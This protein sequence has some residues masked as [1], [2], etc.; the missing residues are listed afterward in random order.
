MSR[1][2]RFSSRALQCLLLASALGVA[3]CGGAQDKEPTTSVAVAKPATRPAAPKQNLLPAGL[4]TTALNDFETSRSGNPLDAIFS[5]NRPEGAAPPVRVALLLPLSGQAASAGRVMLKAAQLALFDAGE[6]R[7][8]LLPHDT[9][10]TVEGA[11]AAARAAL[12]DGAN[13]VLGPLFGAHVQAVAEVVSARKVPVLAFSNDQ[14]A[15]GNGAAVLGLTPETEIR[16][17]LLRARDEGL[18]EIAAFLPDSPYGLLVADRM[19]AISAET[20]TTI[21]QINHYPA[22]SDASDEFL[23]SAA[24]EFASY[25]LRHAALNRERARLEQRNDD[26]SRRALARLKNLD[27]MGDPPFQAV[28]LA[29]S[30][31]R[32]PAIAPLLAFY[33]VDPTRV[34]FLGLSNWYSSELGIEPTLRGAWFPGPDPAQ[35]DSLMNRYA[36][37]YQEHPGR[38]AALAYDAV[39]VA[40]TMAG[41]APDNGRITSDRLL[42]TSGFAAYYGPFRITQSG[43]TERLLSILQVES[44]G[45]A[46]LEPAPAAFD[47]L[48][49]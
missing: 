12:D 47:P 10:S 40:A 22:G 26:I 3:G 38:L 1:Y 20:G 15:A 48:I 45:L 25:D 28:L 46:V 11:T 35:Y 5:L 23:L 43:T 44:S 39:A 21:V 14:S 8:M 24:R 4:S 49:N 6:Q 19:R 16:R 34:Q 9:Q 30:A 18:F 27:T 31:G 33:D 29:E 42:S 2:F 37:F 32:L 17:I 36:A 41:D 7:L 13:L